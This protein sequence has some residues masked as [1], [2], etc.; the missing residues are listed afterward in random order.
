LP[1]VNRKSYVI[2]TILLAYT[3]IYADLF[4]LGISADL[5]CADFNPIKKTSSKLPTSLQDFFSFSVGNCSVTV[6]GLTKCQEKAIKSKNSAQKLM[7][8][9]KYHFGGC[10]SKVKNNKNRNGN[11]QTSIYGYMNGFS[12]SYGGSDGFIV[13]DTSLPDFKEKQFLNT[14]GSGGP[15]T[16][17]DI[18][19]F[20]RRALFVDPNTGNVNFPGGKTTLDTEKKILQDAIEASPFKDNLA[21]TG[22]SLSSSKKEKGLCSAMPSSSQAMLCEFEESLKANKSVNKDVKVMIDSE[23]EKKT[24]LMNVATMSKHNVF[25]PAEELREKL[26]LNKRK[27]FKK[28]A[29]IYASYQALF[30]G[31]MKV[32]GNHR[33]AMRE[34]S[35][36]KDSLSGLNNYPSVSQS[37]ISKN[38]IGDLP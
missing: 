38:K 8:G 34:L 22:A 3:P 17:L 14:G 1:K 24:A 20:D 35:A 32:V 4:N 16:I 27:E 11:N 30:I 6:S 7:G 21:E 36:I 29:D 12:S 31:K 2:A 15:D 9:Y 25:F 28:L 37:E 33:K 23:T 10:A 19:P 13:S 26:P 5:Q 18:S